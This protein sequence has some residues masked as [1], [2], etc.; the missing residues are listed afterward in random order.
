M[1]NIAPWN[2]GRELK[3]WTRSPDTVLKEIIAT[4]E[5][6][7]KYLDDIAIEECSEINLFMGIGFI[8]ANKGLSKGLPIDCLNMIL[9]AR[10][11]TE[12]LHSSAGKKSKIHILIADHLAY[13][14]MSEGN[15]EQAQ[16]LAAE[17][18]RQL[19]MLVKKLGMEARVDFHLSSAIEKMPE[20]QAIVANIQEKKCDDKLV[21]TIR[22]G[23]TNKK[24]YFE[25]QTAQVE[26]FRRVHHCQIKISWSRDSVP[27]DIKKSGCHDE[28]HFDRFYRNL[29]PQTK[30]SFVY[31]DSGHSV[32]EDA[33]VVPYCAESQDNRILFGDVRSR[34]GEIKSKTLC[35]NILTYYRTICK[36]DREEPE[37]SIDEMIVRVQALTL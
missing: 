21:T 19:S 26:Y 2:E 9:V 20:Y 34:P 25:Q 12:A 17:Y 5:L 7:R 37:P 29:L 36:R 31:V 32:A 33:C 23:D 6:C 4:S 10:R 22:K 8:S 15:V 18:Y 3:S 27:K 30:L 13:K 28:A 11:I 35:K 1:M 16:R 24:Y 14:T